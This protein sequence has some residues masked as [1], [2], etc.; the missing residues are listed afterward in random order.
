[1]KQR[2]GL[3]LIAFVLVVL[4]VSLFFM[5]GLAKPAGG[6]GD[7]VPDGGEGEIFPTAVAM[8]ESSSTMVKA[9]PSANSSESSK[10][11]AQQK[12]FQAKISDCFD[13]PRLA[14]AETPEIFFKD[15]IAENP[16]KDSQFEMENTHVQLPDGSLRR[17][18]LIPS[19]SSNNAKTLELRYFKLDG[20]GLPERIPLSRKQTINPSQEFIQSLKDQGKVVFHQLK[21]HQLLQ[22]GTQVALNQVDDKIFEMQIFGA[23]KTFS[24]RA[25][26]CDC[27]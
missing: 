8:A 1:M 24:C 26:K 13:N 17:I 4:F 27:R 11:L 20:E 15:L 9:L 22:D 16:V 21:Q 14:S 3:F 2:R 25:M 5:H 18:H 12:D 19:D 23:D 10:K 6:G 7:K